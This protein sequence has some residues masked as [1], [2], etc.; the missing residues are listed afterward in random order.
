MAWIR[1]TEEPPER[2]PTDVVR[3][4]VGVFGV[5]LAGL[6]AQAES[7][8]DT[9]LFK[10][11]NDLPNSLEE[12]AQFLY[13]LGS[14]LAVIGVV[15]VLVLLK[16]H[17]V[18]LHVAFAGVLAWGVAELLHQFLEPQKI[19]G[20]SVTVRLGDGPI[21]PAMNVA[22]IMSL[23]IVLSPYIV[24][25]LRRVVEVLVLLIALS[26]MY[27]GT[28][29]PADVV[30]GL[31]LGLAA[32]ALVLAVFGAPGG[33]PTLDEISDGL[34]GLGFDVAGIAHADEQVPRAAV[35]DVRLASGERL[36]VDAFGRDQRDGQV[37]AKLWH[38]IMYRDPGVPVF[39]SRLQQAEHIG[40]ALVLAERAEV[41]AS[42][43]VETG[44]AGP[45]AA[46][47][48]TREPA[49]TPLD[50]IDT[51]AITDDV[52]ADAWRNVQ[53]LHAA[54]ISHGNLDPHHLLVDE[55]RISF[56]DFSAADANADPYWI[57]RDSAGLLVATALLV[58]NDRAIRSATAVLGN[59]RVAELIPF[60]QPAALPA[61]VTHGQKH[62]SKS[63]KELR[64]ALTTATGVEDVPPLKVRRL[65]LV[66]IGMLF[67]ILLALAIAIPSIED[68]DWATIQQQFENADWGWVALAWV[69]WPL[70]PMAWG[71]ALMGCVNKDLPFVPTVITQVSCSFLNLITPNGIGGTA[72]Q[73]DYLHHQDVPVASAGSAMVLSTGVGGAIQM[74]LF[75]IAAALTATTVD[76][77]SSSSGSITLGAI[78]VVAALVGVVLFIPKVRGK[79]V[80]ALQKAASDIWAVLRNPKKAMQL[81][82][83]DLAGNLIYPFLLGLCLM[84]F[85]YNLSYAQLVVVQVGAGMMGSVAPVPGGIGVQ[86]AALTAGLTGFGIPANPALATVIV[87]RVITFAIPPIF[88]FFTLRW[89]RAKGYA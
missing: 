32:G 86:E 9:N 29:F 60:V 77:S 14:I 22:V 65:S 21:F 19:Q 89:Q 78:A 83:G 31:F 56:V 50:E 11:V 34:G 67:G 45:E 61:G 37:A 82:G 4:A 13:A 53:R 64:A 41:P 57:N 72:L 5:L 79:V 63:L 80:P 76:T 43:L 1:R 74:I 44:A 59:D 68:V 73:L 7:S 55:G 17:R 3:V 46:M 71:T 35:V 12:A 51:D 47:L 75:L 40:Y 16:K 20:V 54:R 15:L 26:V 58:G 62:L 87:F 6:W 70:I 81:F 33:R 69:L 10:T 27:L 8:L 49:G 85:H 24:R 42:R 30:G 88:G 25:P 23:T 18:A 39:G 84:A 38:W 48:V 36:R 52:L 66:N 28:A 2:R